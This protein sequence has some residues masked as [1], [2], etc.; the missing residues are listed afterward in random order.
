MSP[1]AASGRGAPP[2]DGRGTG[3]PARPPVTSALLLRYTAFQIPGQVLVGIG[4][5]LAWDLFE[6]DGRLALAVVAAWI[7][8]D[9]LLFPLVR[10]AYA[11]GDDRGP[12][13]LRGAR[14]VVVEALAPEGRVRVG[15]ELWRARLREGAGP[16][17]EGS[18]VRVERVEGLTVVVVP[19]DA[20]AP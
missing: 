18:A 14:G 13:G 11:P 15:A 5:W 19:E 2:R 20:D 9:V 12:G 8:K 6:V 1:S 4:A 3:H 16:V 10:V 17:G 7:A